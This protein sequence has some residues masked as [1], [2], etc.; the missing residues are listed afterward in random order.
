MEQ[1][2]SILRLQIISSKPL[3]AHSSSK[4]QNG[5]NE[6]KTWTCI[7]FNWCLHGHKMKEISHSII[8]KNGEFLKNCQ[9]QFSTTFHTMMIEMFM[10]KVEINLNFKSFNSEWCTQKNHFFMLNFYCSFMKNLSGD[11]FSVSHK[12][13]TEKMHK[14]AKK[15][16]TKQ[17]HLNEDESYIH[18]VR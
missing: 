4:N 3:A 5:Q 15:R 11:K 18:L 16:C 14:A 8:I 7:L 10:N 2:G 13:G 6:S 12:K 1:L 9:Q 17:F